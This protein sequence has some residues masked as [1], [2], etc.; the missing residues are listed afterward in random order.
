MGKGFFST[1]CPRLRQ[2]LALISEVA[3]PACS[4]RWPQ[5]T[6]GL[7]QLVVPLFSLL[8]PQAR[9]RFSTERQGPLC[10]C[11]QGNEKGWDSLGMSQGRLR[12]AL[13]PGD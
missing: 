7:A 8:P 6:C 3:G 12:N 13:F 4:Q 9:P 5:R 11:A 10:P 1:H 2:V